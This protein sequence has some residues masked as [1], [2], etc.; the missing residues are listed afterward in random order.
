M[1]LESITYA[2]YKLRY[3]KKHEHDDRGLSAPTEEKLRSTYPTMSLANAC[4]KSY[5]TELLFSDYEL[6]TVLSPVYAYMLRNV[7][8]DAPASLMDGICSF[9]GGL[10]AHTIGYLRALHGDA[11]M[12]ARSLEMYLSQYVFLCLGLPTTDNMRDVDSVLSS[13][14]VSELQS[15]GDARC[16]YG[17]IVGPSRHTI[18]DIAES[19]CHLLQAVKKVQM[20]MGLTDEQ[21]VLLYLAYAIRICKESKRA[22]LLLNPTQVKYLFEIYHES[23][24]TTVRQWLLHRLTPAPVVAALGTLRDSLHEILRLT[25]MA[26]CNILTQSGYAI[27]REKDGN[28]ITFYIRAKDAQCVYHVYKEFPQINSSIAYGLQLAI[29]AYLDLVCKRTWDVTES[30]AQRAIHIWD[31]AK[32]KLGVKPIENINVV[33]IGKSY[34]CKV[35]TMTD[36]YALCANVHGYTEFLFIDDTGAHC[37]LSNPKEFLDLFDDVEVDVCQIL[38]E[39]TK[40]KVPMELLR[41]IVTILEETGHLK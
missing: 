23:N 11:S 21:A 15:N 7:T 22:Y 33:S 41:I 37:S 38:Y 13:V 30:G 5:G 40:G 16:L 14:S 18:L 6:D 26:G 4:V 34:V 29:L 2:G 31:N 17:S 1:Q 36:M 39:R 20:L 3:Q 19:L 35:Q 8:S 32:D 12:I 24:P 28:T 10:D 25:S 27:I 9:E